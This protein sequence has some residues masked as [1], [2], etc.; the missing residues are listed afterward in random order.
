MRTLDNGKKLD[1]LELQNQAI[2]CPTCR[3]RIRGVRVMPG[4]VMRNVSIKCRD[5]RA[6]I[7]VNID[8]ASATYESPRR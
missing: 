2:I 7:I 5:C 8:Q 6:E 3:R 1:I 4:G